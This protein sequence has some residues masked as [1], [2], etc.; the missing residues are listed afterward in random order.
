MS[1]HRTMFEKYTRPWRV[2]H[3]SVGYFY[4][5]SANGDVPLGEIH[6]IVDL[7]NL[8]SICDMVNSSGKSLYQE[9]YPLGF[10]VIL[11]LTIK[12]A[13]LFS[14]NGYIIPEAEDINNA[15]KTLEQQYPAAKQQID[16]WYGN[17]NGKEEQR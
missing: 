8:Q 11:D 4:I 10:D 7:A 3:S 1:E 16:D 6:H 9:E 12:F 15:L 13:K 17:R 5:V 14:K 2:E